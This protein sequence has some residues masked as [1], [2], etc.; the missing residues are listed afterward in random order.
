MAKIL[1]LTSSPDSSYQKEDG[2]WVTG[3][4]NRRNGFYERMKAVWPEHPAGVLGIASDPENDAMNDEM[5]GYYTKML[6]ASELPVREIFMLDGRTEKKLDEWLAKSDFIILSGGHVPTENAF[7]QKIGLREKLADWDGIIMGI[8]AG[9]MNAADDVY[10]QPELPGESTDPDYE[11]HIQGLGLTNINILPHYQMVKDNMLDGRRLFEDITFE[12]SMGYTFY[13]LEDGS[14]VLSDET[15]ETLY[16][17]AYV[18]RDG[19]MEM[20]CSEDESVK[21]S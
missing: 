7:F 15:G 12:D 9:P 1:F 16:G 10:A 19:K 5:M 8:S 17:N 6:Q 13:V 20:I 18:I 21:L 14:Y 2:T 3:P 4:L 11:R